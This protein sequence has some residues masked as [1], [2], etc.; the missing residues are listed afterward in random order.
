VRGPFD[1]VQQVADA[2]DDRHVGPVVADGRQMIRTAVAIAE[3]GEIGQARGRDFTIER[4]G[5]DAVSRFGMAT[6]LLQVP[7]AWARAPGRGGR[8]RPRG[9]SSQAL[10]LLAAL[11]RPWGWRPGRRARSRGGSGAASAVVAAVLLASVASPLGSYALLE[12]SEPV[13]A[14]ALALALARRARRG[15]SRPAERGGSRSAAGAPPGSPCSPR[16]ACSWPRP[17]A[18]A[19]LDPAAGRS[20][21]RARPRGR[22]RRGAP[23]PLGGLRVRP[24]RALFGGYPDDRFTTRG[25]TASG[26]CSSGRT[27]GCC[28]SGRRSSSSPGRGRVA[29]RAWLAERPR[30]RLARRRRWCSPRSSPWRRA[31]GAGTAWRAGDRG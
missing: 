19:A 20:A 27:A 1:R 22:R 15:R 8:L 4:P 17:G 3:T 5:G 11:A 13:Q 2:G 18:A 6:S 9:A 30:A 25:S 26:G 10:F 16:A 28:C 29:R 12:F 24:L 21:A 14:A 7:A 23:R 31:T